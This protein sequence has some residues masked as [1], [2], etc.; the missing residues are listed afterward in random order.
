[1]VQMQKQRTSLTSST[2]T[3]ML[4]AAVFAM[5]K[6]ARKCHKALGGTFEGRRVWVK[7]SVSGQCPSATKTEILNKISPRPHFH[8][9][10]EV[11]FIHLKTGSIFN[12]LRERNI[13][14]S[15]VLMVPHVTCKA[16]AI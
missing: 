14:P 3:T 8:M 9:N 12:L 16:I 10:D 6:R 1:M 5:K 13:Y 7:L 11:D 4:S 2:T 15:P